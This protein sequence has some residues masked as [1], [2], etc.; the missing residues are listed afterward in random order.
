MPPGTEIQRSDCKGLDPPDADL[1]EKS[2]SLNNCFAQSFDAELTSMSLVS[3]SLFGGGGQGASDADRERP[4][5]A[6]GAAVS[7]Q[8]QQQE[9]RSTE[10]RVSE[11][12][13]PDG[14]VCDGARQDP[15]S[16]ERFGG[17]CSSESRSA[18]GLTLASPEGDRR[19]PFSGRGRDN[20]LRSLVHPSNHRLLLTILRWQR[21]ARMRRETRLVQGYR[22]VREEAFN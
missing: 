12:S 22:T 7:G 17:S 20:R 10:C 8:L 18:V 5:L 4:D 9:T 21:S 3:S 11:V 14:D 15:A 1:S 6:A 16:R 2:D 13:R 19:T